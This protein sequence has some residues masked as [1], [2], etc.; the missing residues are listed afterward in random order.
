MPY[1]TAFR[2][3]SSLDGSAALDNRLD[4]RR[5]HAGLVAKRLDNP[6]R[7]NLRAPHRLVTRGSTV[8]T[9]RSDMWQTGDVVHRLHCDALTSYRAHRDGAA[10]TGL[11]ARAAAYGLEVIMG[12]SAFLRRTRRSAA[13]R[14]VSTS[15][16]AAIAFLVAGMLLVAC[17]N[18]PGVQAEPPTATEPSSTIGSSTGSASTL[19]PTPTDIAAV[20]RAQVQVRY[21][22]YHEVIAEAG[23]ASDPDDPRL[24]DYATGAVLANL[25]GTFALRRGARDGV[26][27]AGRSPRSQVS[28]SPTARP[29]SRTVWTTRRRALRT[30]RERDSTSGGPNS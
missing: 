19:S 10:Q 23:A 20:T 28:R 6:V 1:P 11:S 24:A 30:R 22:Q 17:S 4:N 26:C 21:E 29:W 13:T 12:G 14:P 3:T 27:T 7:V 16:P 18:E 15:G 5:R 9:R 25:R 8:V 2:T